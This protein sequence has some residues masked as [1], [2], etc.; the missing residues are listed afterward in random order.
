MRPINKSKLMAAILRRL[1]DDHEMFVKAARAAHAEA[2]HEQSKAESK[3][4]TRGLEA[5]YLAIGQGRK[6]ADLE[7]DMAALEKLGAPTFAVKDPVDLGALVELTSTTGSSFYFVA[8][9]AGGLEVEFEKME[10]W[11]ITPQSP[12]GQLLMGRAA[13][14]KFRFGAGSSAVTYDIVEVR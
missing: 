6:I 2:T 10:I 9:R 7:E 1:R 5:G 14:E 11:V 13:G 8:P 3:Y 4:D 12:I